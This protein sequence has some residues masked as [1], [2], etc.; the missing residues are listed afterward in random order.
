M[1]HLHLFYLFVTTLIGIVSLGIVVSD[2]FKS[3]E[4]FILNYIWFHTAL[5]LLVVS[6]L[7]SSY[8]L[9]NLP[10]LHPFVLGFLDY[11]NVFV[12]QYALMVTFPFL[13]HTFF[14]VPHVKKRNLIFIALALIFCTTEHVLE[15]WLKIDSKAIL[16]Y[17]LDNLVLILVFFYGFVTGISEYKHLHEAE[18]ARLAKQFLIL[19]GIF[20][21]AI[22]VDTLLYDSLP[23]LLYPIIYCGISIT[24]TY[25]LAQYV[26]AH[27]RNAKSFPPAETAA[28]GMSDESDA[29]LL[30][31]DLYR[32][33]GISPREQDVLPLVLQGSSN[34]QIGETLF[35][36]LSTVKA[37]LRNIYAKFG[38]K[39]RYELVA[40]LKHGDDAL[41]PRLDADDQA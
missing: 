41:I 18:K 22:I 25:H 13:I 38:V 39:N 15:F 34:N 4:K 21:P 5:T 37:H 32:Q 28:E 33:Y 8:I 20:M 14:N 31:E 26:L 27:A 3:R 23:V 6:A 17:D 19:L 12:A 24:F 30:T 40:L 7:L 10:G 9:L 2:Y 16:P 1:Q 29:G 11:L 36:S 35:I